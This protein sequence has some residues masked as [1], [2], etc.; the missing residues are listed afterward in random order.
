MENYLGY[1]DLIDIHSEWIIDAWLK[2]D[3]L[4]M[5]AHRNSYKTT[6]IIIV[7]SIWY[8]LLYNP[9][10]TCL[11]IR[12]AQS[13]ARKIVKTISENLEKPECSLLG[14]A[15]YNQPVLK[16]KKWSVDSLSLSI[17]KS[18]TPEGNIDCIGVGGSITG[19]HYDYILPD[20]IITLKD[21]ISKAERENTESFVRELKNIK[22]RGGKLY[23]SGSPWHRGDAWTICPEPKK[24][25]IGTVDIPG[26]R[27]DELA[28]TMQEL[29]RGN[30][31]SLI[32]ANY[33][34]VHIS[35]EERIFGD[36]DFILWNFDWRTVFAHIDPAYHGTHTTALTMI[37]K[38]LRK[39]DK[40]SAK[41]KSKNT[42]GN[43]E[44]KNTQI[45]ERRD[46]P[47]S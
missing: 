16:S 47:S 25:P 20:D 36:P 21:R 23:I 22:K 32:S 14:K 46:T 38:N 39:K 30:T 1:T 31:E 37:A 4:A 13:E 2:K 18:V 5:Q 9:D 8:L 41:D 43:A 10:V 17:K 33:K 11:I 34:L 35:D 3:A 24:Y 19:S 6:S 28:E 26:Y 12:K 7:G 44:R 15:I 45:T 29:R 42:F 27:E 40:D